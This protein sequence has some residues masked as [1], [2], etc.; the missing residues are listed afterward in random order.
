MALSLRDALHLVQL[1]FLA[2]PPIRTIHKV[3]ADHAFF[4]GL[5][6]QERNEIIGIGSV[7]E[8]SG[9]RILFHHQDPYH[10]FFLI[11]TGQVQIYRTNDAGRPMVLHVLDAGESFAEVPL[12]E[13]QAH[14]TYPATAQTLCD[15]ELLYLPATPFVQ[16]IESH[17]HVYLRMMGHMAKRL[18]RLADRLEGLALHD[19]CTRLAHHLLIESASTPKAPTVDLNR[20]KSVLAAEL[21]TVP[22]TLSRALRELETRGLIRNE[23][24]CIILLDEKE[25]A[26]I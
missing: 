9:D 14:P 4:G 25:L 20:P 16:Y 22:E 23:G 17:P 15:S 19:V 3:L 8:A 24:D 2:M 11:I 6:E 21:G 13:A 5:T 18:R 1:V 12:F 26:E 10:G 7:K